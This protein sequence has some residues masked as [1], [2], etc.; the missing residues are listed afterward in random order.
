MG[1]LRNLMFFLP[2]HKR[3]MEQYQKDN[4]QEY[5]AEKQ[6]LEMEYGKPFE[7]FSNEKKIGYMN[8][9][10]WPYWLYNDIVGYLE[11]GMDGHNHLTANIFIKRKYLPRAHLFRRGGSRTTLKNNQYLYYCEIDKEK[12]IDLTENKYFVDS[13][14]KIIDKA[15]RVIRKRNKEFILW[16]PEYKYNCFD[17][18]LAYKQINNDEKV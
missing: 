17:F 11:I 6:Y 8:C 1:V 2:I 14:N 5:A 13:L 10:V 18:A 15:K 12:V 16:L 4:E 7:E 9:W 3:S